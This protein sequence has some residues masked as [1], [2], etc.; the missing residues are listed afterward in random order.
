M[1][2]RNLLIV[3]SLFLAIPVSAGQPDFALPD[4]KGNIHH[5]SDYRGKW[6][7]VNYW[8]TWCPPCLEEIPELVDFY[9]QHHAKDAVVLGINYEDSD[10]DYLQSFIDENMISY[11]ILRANL[12]RAPAFGRLLGLPTTFIVSPKGELV[13]SRTGSVTKAFLEEVIKQN[14]KH[15]VVVTK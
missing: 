9:E 1:P 4:V 7:V 15:E 5:L 14:Q 6:V 8:A 10:L 3:L 12:R 11:P 2:I 13:Q